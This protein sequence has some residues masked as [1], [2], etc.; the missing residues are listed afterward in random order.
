MLMKMK[1]LVPAA[2]ASVLAATLALTGCGGSKATTVQGIV[3]LVDLANNVLTVRVDAGNSAAFKLGPA[4]AVKLNE[5]QV[6]SSYLEPGL[7]VTAQVNGNAAGLIEIDLAQ[8][9]ATIVSVDSGRL[10]LQ[11]PA[12]S[13]QVTL[14]SKPF[15]IVRQNSIDVPL[16]ALNPGRI[17]QVSF[18]TASGTAYEVYEMPED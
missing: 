14:N 8:M 16:N 9:E 4:T 18:C 17:A 11:A 1:S 2:T 10:V 6:D 15:T 5:R 13:Q 12:S 7:S 3:Q